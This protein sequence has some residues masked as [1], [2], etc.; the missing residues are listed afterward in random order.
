M[1]RFVRKLEPNRRFNLRRC[2]P[3]ITKIKSAQSTRSPE[4][5]VSA[6]GLV[7]A[8]RT[9]YPS[10]PEKI[11]SA[12][13]LRRR[14]RLHTNSRFI[15]SK[16]YL[17]R[18][19]LAMTRQRARKGRVF[20]KLLPIPFY[21]QLTGR[22]E[23]ELHRCQRSKKSNLAVVAG[24]RV[25]SCSTYLSLKHRNDRSGDR[26]YM[27]GWY[28]KLNVLSWIRRTLKIPHLRWTG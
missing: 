27:E 2:T 9:V 12:V 8:D 5:V 25:F 22:P 13:G 11:A 23:S 14:F 1:R 7:P 20:E 26:W 18:P 19:C 24:N 21:R 28:T 10:N 16:Y 4:M 17:H 15:Q 3:S 6:S